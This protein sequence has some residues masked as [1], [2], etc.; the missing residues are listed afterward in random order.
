MV[1]HLFLNNKQYSIR[2]AKTGVAKHKDIRI[3][4]KL[5]GGLETT[6]GQQLFF[7]EIFIY[8]TSELMLKKRARAYILVMSYL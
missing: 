2:G 6:F 8:L 1:A 7:L 3:R 5:G 4:K